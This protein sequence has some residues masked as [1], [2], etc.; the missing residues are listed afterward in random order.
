MD[1][2][3]SFLIFVSSQCAE[4]AQ[5]LAAFPGDVQPAI[6]FAYITGWRISEVRKLTWAQSRAVGPGLQGSW[7][8]LQAGPRPSAHGGP[9]SRLSRSALRRSARSCAGNARVSVG[10][11]GTGRNPRRDHSSRLWWGSRPCAPAAGAHERLMRAIVPWALLFPGSLRLPA[12]SRQ[13]EPAYRH[14]PEPGPPPVASKLPTGFVI[15]C[16]GPGFAR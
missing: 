12:K 9:Q 5:V 10:I 14:N 13:H 6:E 1:S 7:L 11:G 8:P 4:I 16:D 2:G 15:R 3:F